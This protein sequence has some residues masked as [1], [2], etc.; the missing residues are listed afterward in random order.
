MAPPIPP[1][2]RTAGGARAGRGEED[3]GSG[4]SSTRKRIGRPATLAELSKRATSGVH[5]SGVQT[6]DSNIPISRYLI[7][8]E[9]LTRQ[10]ETCLKHEDDLEGAFIAL[11]KV[12]KL[13]IETLPYQHEGYKKLDAATKKKMKE[14]G[15]QN[16]D[17]LA[18][19]KLKVVDRFEEWRRANPDAPLEEESE[20][21]TST[22]KGKAASASSLRPVPSTGVMENR[23][24]E[25]SLPS[26]TSNPSTPAPRS[27][28]YVKPEAAHTGFDVRD[29]LGQGRSIASTSSSTNSR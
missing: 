6:V 1:V 13:L 11:V 18:K 29:I 24:A 7:G 16:L 12:C 3:G 5:A 20:N 4:S 14:K 22:T 9:T 17:Q 2:F 19:V 28:Q 25:S 27:I 15:Q 21:A 10:A 23:P 26:T 8:S